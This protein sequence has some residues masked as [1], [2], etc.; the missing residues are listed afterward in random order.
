MG[1]ANIGQEF[2]THSVIHHLGQGRDVKKV[3]VFQKCLSCAIISPLISFPS[4]PLDRSPGLCISTLP[5]M[6]QPFWCRKT[7]GFQKLP[8]GGCYTINNL[9]NGDVRNGGSTAT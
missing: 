8:F 7:K 5:G 2:E 6:P 9:E 4:P 3:K 1:L